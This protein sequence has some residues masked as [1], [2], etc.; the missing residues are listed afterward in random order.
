[1]LLPGSSSAEGSWSE[2]I[3]P[4][5]AID[6][7][8]YYVVCPNALGSCYGSTGPA[9]I[10]PRTG[11]PYGLDFPAITLDDVIEAQRRLIDELGVRRLAAVVGPSLGAMQAFNWAVRYPER[12]GRVVAAVGAPFNPGIV[13]VADTLRAVRQAI[14]APAG[15][16]G[17]LLQQRITTLESYGIDAELR[18]RL[19]DADARR[20][21]VHRLAEE[22]AADFDAATLVVLARAI[23]RFDVRGQ[24]GRMRA[25]LLYVLSRSDPLFPPSLLHQL[26]PLFDAA[27]VRWSYA[28]I[29]S[30][31]GHL[32]SG[33]DSARWAPVL[34]AFLQSK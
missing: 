11:R 7:D 27:G 28:E 12:V 32:A 29:D 26:A 19:P 5:R 6:T 3:G 17:F 24:L 9:S 33:A 18:D 34:A 10:D 4:G 30:D 2:L 15:A 13:N 22:W 16:R 14:A 1:M 8:R 20:Q 21:E 23:E 31:K 25:P